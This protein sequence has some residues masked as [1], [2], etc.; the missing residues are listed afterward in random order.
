M[1]LADEKFLLLTNLVAEMSKHPRQNGARSPLTVKSRALE[2]L[3]WLSLDAYAEEYQ[4]LKELAAEGS[5]RKDG[6][7]GSES[8]SRDF[9]REEIHQPR[10]LVPG[11]D[12]GGQHGPDEGG[13][14][15]RVSPRLQVFHLRD[16]VD[17]QAI[18]RSIADQARTIR[19][20]VHM[21]ETINKLM[22]VQKQLV[23]EYGREPTPEEVAEEI[24]LPGRARARGFEDGAAADFAAGA[25]RR[26]RRDELR[27]LHRGQRC[28][29]SERHDGDRASR[30]RRS[31]MSSET[32][33]ERERQVLEQRFGLVDGY[34]RTLEEV[35][36]QFKVTRER[37][38]QIEAKALAQDASSRPASGNSRASSTPPRFS[39]RVRRS[40]TF[41]ACPNCAHRATFAASSR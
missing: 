30:R 40:L 21:I 9:D 6:N 17:R 24:L 38:R 5:A 39:P 20:P 33:T 12:S 26:Q 7:G 16:V 8:A 41:K 13:R 18:T 14:E 36:R 2:S 29:E 37:I 4:S 27:R 28:G 34:S 10:S 22:R 3:L 32:L 19:I 15:I 25:G 31:E 11:L 35:G 1:H 23:Q